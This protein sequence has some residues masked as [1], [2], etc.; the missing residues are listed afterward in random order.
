MRIFVHKENDVFGSKCRPG[1]SHDRYRGSHWTAQQ[2]SN[3]HFRSDITYVTDTISRRRKSR[4]KPETGFNDTV[5]CFEFGDNANRR[6]MHPM[7]P[8]PDASPEQQIFEPF[9]LPLRNKE[10]EPIV[11][12]RAPFPSARP[13]NDNDISE[14]D[15]EE[16]ETKE[17]IEVDH[18]KKISEIIMNMYRIG[19]YI[20]DSRWFSHAITVILLMLAVQYI[21]FSE[22]KLI[23]TEPAHVSDRIK[24]TNDP[25]MNFLI[26]QQSR[27]EKEINNL[28]HELESFAI[29]SKETY[30]MELKNCLK[31]SSD[32]RNEMSSNVLSLE[33][34]LRQ[35]QVRNFFLHFRYLFSQN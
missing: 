25:D 17:E 1:E 14:E 11:L 29:K 34:K 28:R 35:T 15:T 22:K 18:L 8:I 30:S 2:D 27:M 10:E 6:N 21:N 16:E 19:K 9:D 20:I 5:S 31:I 3:Y 26:F 32:I 33:D 7:P 13:N 23:Q 24:D 12:L 4:N